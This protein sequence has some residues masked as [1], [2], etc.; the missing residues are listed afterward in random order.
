MRCIV[1]ETTDVRKCAAVL[2]TRAKR[3]WQPGQPRQAGADALWD[4]QGTYVAS[5]NWR[6]AAGVKNLLDA[7]PPATN[8][9]AGFFPG[10]NPQIANPLG[11]LFYLRATN[12]VK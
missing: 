7:K 5:A 6:F 4:L 9:P 8:K 3:R 11:R 10:Y 2:P 1:E 12:A